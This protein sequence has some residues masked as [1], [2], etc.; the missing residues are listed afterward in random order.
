MIGSY[1][2]WAIGARVG[3]MTAFLTS[4]VVAGVGL[5]AGIRFAAH[6]EG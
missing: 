6:L 5:W 1:I 4:V 3:T 2:G